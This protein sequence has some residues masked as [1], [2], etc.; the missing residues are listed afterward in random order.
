MKEVLAFIRVNK[1]EE[2]KKALELNG[3]FSYSWRGC[4]GR[5]REILSSA[6]QSLVLAAQGDNTVPSGFPTDNCRLI[7]KRFFSIIVP[8]DEVSRVVKLLIDV[9]QT[10]NHGDGKIFVL[11]ASEDYAI[12]SVKNAAKII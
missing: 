9:N 3:F 2:T 1:V 4:I 6:G 5:G 8:D 7:A 10:G 11:K 12:K